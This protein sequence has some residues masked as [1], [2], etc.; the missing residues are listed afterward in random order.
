MY[1]GDASLC[2]QEEATR[3]SLLS[4]DVS[5]LP[6]KSQNLKPTFI[7]EANTEFRADA[8]VRQQ[9]EIIRVAQ[10][11]GGTIT[12][13]FYPEAGGNKVGLGLFLKYLMGD[14]HTVQIGS[15]PVHY[16]GF[17]VARDLFDPTCGTI[18]EKGISVHVNRPVIC[19]TKA[20]FPFSGMRVSGMTL[21]Q[22]TNASLEVAT[23]LFGQRAHVKTT[24]IGGETYSAIAC[25]KSGHLTIC[26]APVPSGVAPNY[27]GFTIGGNTIKTRSL[28]IT[29]ANGL[30]D[31]YVLGSK[32][33]YPDETDIGMVT[34]TV[35][36]S[37]PARDPASGFSSIDT[38]EKWISDV[39]V[40]LFF[41]WDNGTAI[42]AAQN[43]LLDIHFPKL[44][45]TDSNI[46]DVL[47]G[48]NMFDMTATAQVNTADL[49]AIGIFMQNSV[50]SY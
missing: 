37:A 18:G 24:E 35:A 38:F 2:I 44:H 41:R 33:D 5:W 45:I 19:S 49:Y 11:C 29:L 28:T 23:E 46:A 50:A 31:Q 27:N 42:A 12:T 21:T 7:E 15:S 6:I 47:E 13:N 32:K 16:H 25:F 17:K 40:E 22:A 30:T 1:G 39:D 10:S 14:V 20:A 8:T 36:L 34:A 43:Y 48:E 3:G 26:D 9:K 4:D